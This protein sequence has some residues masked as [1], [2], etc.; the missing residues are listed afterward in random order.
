MHSKQHAQAFHEQQR[1]ERNIDKQPNIGY[2]IRTKPQFPH[3]KINKQHSLLFC[4]FSQKIFPLS[5]QMCV[6][7]QSYT[8]SP[9]KFKTLVQMHC[10]KV[11]KVSVLP[12]IGQRGHSTHWWVWKRCESGVTAF[13]FTRSQ[14]TWMQILGW[15]VWQPSPTLFTKNT[16]SIM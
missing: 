3:G 9:N 1:E 12:C 14:P 10:L 2:C 7:S 4:I 16:W 8:V 11:M 15:C 6:C 5:S 13:A